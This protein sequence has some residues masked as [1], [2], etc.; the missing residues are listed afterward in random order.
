M[1]PGLRI[2]RGLGASIAVTLGLL[3]APGAVSAEAPTTTGFS[4]HSAAHSTSDGSSVQV[5]PVDAKT[6]AKLGLHDGCALTITSSVAAA[7]LQ[8]ATTQSTVVP[9]AAS[10]T[11]C[12]TVKNGLSYGWGG[13]TGWNTQVS[14]PVCTNHKTVWNGTAGGSGWGPRCTYGVP[15]GYTWTQQWC[16]MYNNNHTVCQAGDD[17][18]AQPAVPVNTLYFWFR[19]YMQPSPLGGILFTIDGGNH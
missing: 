12:T 14:V 18:Y 17:W 11:Y 4:F 19:L 6:C 9:A 5:L 10:A 2:Q 1:R 8:A 3:I 13:M 16:G 7:P 15:W